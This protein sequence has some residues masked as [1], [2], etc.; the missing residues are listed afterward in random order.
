MTART[1]TAQHDRPAFEVR[2]AGTA[3]TP[4]I[5]ADVVEIDVHE[6]VCRHGRL[7]LLLQ[8]W[9]ADTRTV[10]HSDTAPFTPGAAIAV[11]MGYHDQLRDVF[12]GV[13]VSLTTHFP[14]DGRPVLRVEGRSRSILLD[15]PAR[16]RQLE[17]VNDAGV[18]AA[19]AA[20]YSLTTDAA[21]GVTRPF[22]VSDR[23][24]DWAMLTRRAA[25]LGWVTYVRGTTLVLRPPARKNAPVALE[26]T[27]SL[28]ELHLTQDISAS[29]DSVVGVAWDIDTLSAATS[30][31]GSGAAGIDVG[32]RADH[33]RA[34]RAAGWPL[35]DARLES[36]AVQATAEADARAA[37]AQRRAALAHYTGTGV[38]EG[39]PGLRCDAWVTIAGVG[40]RMS[41]PHYV[42]ATRHRLSGRG[43]VTEFQVGTPPSL[44][45][46][47][48][49]S[50]AP[51]GSSG[52]GSGLLL[53][54][55]EALD[56]PESLN[57]VRVR[58]PWRQDSGNGVWARQSCLDAG[59]GYGAV[60]VPTPGQEV[61]VGFVDGD[62]AMPVVL[63]SLFNGT[64]KPPL[65]V[66]AKTDAV[67]TLVSPQGH[68]I[69]M[70]DGDAA[71]V[72]V[73]TGKGNALVLDDAGS[74]ITVTHKDSGNAIT[75][76]SKGIELTAAM[77]DIVLTCSGGTVKI[78]SATLKATTTGAVAIDSSAGA[79]LRAS[80]SL[81]L[82]GSLVTI[83]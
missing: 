44:R 48:E 27:T 34:V 62:P 40:S 75:L 81:G 50:A 19:V 5:A 10:R 26:Y 16:S 45:P 56:D 32:D 76:S 73:G 51:Q 13:V 71:A 9:D 41:G 61:V 20:D 2:V 1:T 55:V 25:E 21:D 64:Q 31:Q 65:V 69:R 57:R 12:D 37:G 58:L 72:T 47:P 33:A 17:K 36:P 70:E 14:R 80:G 22:V 15:H 35:R 60:F 43:Y 46:P 30:Q 53:G 4:Q 74:Q 83:N 67:R 6:E 11:S 68:A 29:V 39:D 8:N 18:A 82:K 78:D 3:V 49:K 52:Q 77:G 42:T 38:V 28:V 63:G 54:V 79:D 7:T 23:I 59:D 24:S 66:D